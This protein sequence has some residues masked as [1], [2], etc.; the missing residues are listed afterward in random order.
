MSSPFDVLAASYETTWSAT[1]EGR[2]Q[3]EEVWRVVDE[4]FRSG[5]RVIDLGCGTGDDAL[6]LQAH[7]V[8][9]YG[10]DSSQKM[11]EI[12]RSRQVDAHWGWMEDLASVQ[13]TFSGALSNFGALN[14][15]L[16]LEPVAHQLARLIRARGLVALCVMG[17]FC[18]RET[19]RFFFQGKFRKATRRWS[20]RAEWRG[21][22]IRYWSGTA[23]RR[24]FEDHFEFEKRIAVGRGDHQLYVFRRRAL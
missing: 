7:G 14:C 10:I 16:Q 21:T 9:V 18:W 20:G 2:G 19:M 23:V 17:P 24:A 13:G 4:L 8:E 1:T 15:V 22:V 3:R 5:D 6:H 12:A 11:V